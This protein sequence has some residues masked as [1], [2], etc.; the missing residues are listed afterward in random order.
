MTKRRF[1]VVLILISIFLSSSIVGATILVSNES[2]TMITGIAIQVLATLLFAGFIAYYFFETHNWFGQILDLVEQPISITDSKMG[3]T[4]INK[5][6]E[7]M[8]NLQRSDILGKHCSNWGAKICNTQDCGVN[9]LQKGKQ[10]TLFDQFGKN[11]RVNTNYLY[12]FRGK[13][14]GHA[15]IVTDITDKVQFQALKTKMSTDVSR[16]LIELNEGATRLSSSTQEVSAAVEEIFAS[17]ETSFNNSV[18]T[19]SKANDVAIQ[20]DD[21]RGNLENSITAVQEI[22]NRVGLIQEIA[23]QTNLLAL[24][25]A[26]EAARAG[27]MGKGFAVVAGEVRA[28]AEKSQAAANEIEGLTTSTQTVSEEAGN[29]LRDLVPNIRQTAEL[30][31][32]INASTLEQKTGMEQIN[33]AIQTVSRVAQESNS[34]AESLSTAFRELENFG[35]EEEEV[36]TSNPEVV[37]N[38]PAQLPPADDFERF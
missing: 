2:I 28:L 6:V 4:F 25:A 15:E 20:A 30:V 34:I 1:I 9:C 3:W 32:E 11:F 22:V 21:T 8:L 14:I 26:I 5:P 16:L 33:E 18:E 7:A 13:E 38:K 35:Q 12:N 19:E 36:R 23:R 29:C 24:N 17:L 31:S 37:A 27:D 10:E